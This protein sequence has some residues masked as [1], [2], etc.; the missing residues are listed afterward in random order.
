M[1]M[2]KYYDIVRAT[3]AARTP[4]GVDNPLAATT[5]PEGVEDGVL[6]NINNCGG[7]FKSSN[8]TCEEF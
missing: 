3:V 8:T 4:I 6:E 5:S 1:T 2:K 7:K